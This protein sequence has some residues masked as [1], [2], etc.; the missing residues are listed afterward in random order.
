MGLGG[1][2]SG[3]CPSL[4][5]SGSGQR[6]VLVRPVSCMA[7]AAAHGATERVRPERYGCAAAGRDA[8]IPPNPPWRTDASFG[9]GATGRPARVCPVRSANGFSEIQTRA[10]LP[11]V[12]ITLCASG[13]WMRCVWSLK[14]CETSS[15][16]CTA[17]QS[18]CACPGCSLI[19]VSR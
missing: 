16:E 4:L 18:Q 19:K 5:Q 15:G 14:H 13:S 2:V 10:R 12:M 9:S 8:S 3:E 1:S 11:N 17:G 7:W 6:G